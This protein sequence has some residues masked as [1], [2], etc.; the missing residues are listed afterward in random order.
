VI[1]VA[2]ESG[3]EVH[4]YTSRGEGFLSDIPGVIYHDNFYI[5]SRFRLITLFTF[6]LSQLILFFFLLRWRKENCLFYTNTILPFTSIWAAKLLKKKTVVHVHEYEI[7]PKLLNNFLFWVVRNSADQVVTVSS[8]LANNAALG[9]RASLVV[10]NCAPE[11]FRI[12]R[13]KN[14][15]PTQ[16]F[17]VL[18]LASLRTYKGILE[19]EKLAS[20][21][22]HIRFRLVL[23]DSA[24]QV[25]EW[26]RERKLTSN[27]EILPVQREV[28]SL[29]R[30]AS[31]VLNLTHPDQCLE[32]FG[33][34]ILEAMHLGIPAIAPTK[35]GC[36][37]LIEDGGSGY[38]VDYTDLDRIMALIISVSNE[39][40]LWN[41]LS[42][43]AFEKC[44][45]FSFEQFRSKLSPLF[46][47]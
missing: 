31:L 10:P 20:K 39:E 34:T 7:S 24:H 13:I 1:H 4:L 32:T 23:S 18:M 26:Y 44:A 43:R 8:F 16:G 27:L 17:S 29:Y 30:E 9:N 12:N 3:N 36:I 14:T 38:L 25:E 47:A 35:G 42:E 45:D 5:R 41:R 15:F 22:P 11:V 19:F 28:I 2:L 46:L 21:L 6:F 40:D 37:E 33:M